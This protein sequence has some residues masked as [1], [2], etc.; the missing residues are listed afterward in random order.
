G[1]LTNSKPAQQND[2]ELINFEKLLSFYKKQ[3]FE[4]YDRRFKLA[5]MVRVML[6]KKLI[7]EDQSVVLDEALVGNHHQS[8]SFYE[9]I[10]LNNSPR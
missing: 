10:T 5:L 8:L 9:K 6:D 3:G 4:D 7:D 2:Y 1:T